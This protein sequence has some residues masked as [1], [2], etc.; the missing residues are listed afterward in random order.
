MTRL[1]NA[2][3]GIFA[4]LILH[5]PRRRPHKDPSGFGLSFAEQTVRTRDGHRLACWLV[6]P[7]SRRV[8]VLGHGIGQ[9]KSASLRTAQLLVARGYQVLM[10]DHRGHGA[11][12]GDRRIWRVADRFTD[13]IVSASRWMAERSHPRILVVFGYSFSTFP[14]VYALASGTLPAD[15]VVCESGPGLNLAGMFEGFLLK[16]SERSTPLGRLMRSPGLRHATAA[17]AVRMLGANWPPGTTEGLLSD[18]PQLY[19][20]GE[21]DTVIHPGEVS[22]LVGAWSCA[23]VHRIPGGHLRLSNSAGAEYDRLVGEFLYGVEQNIR[24]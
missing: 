23:E 20:V 12:Q 6:G 14:T 1:E 22:A 21:E 16:A 17:A 9:G 3:G 18:V 5:P 10:F 2:L 7:D 8:A 4:Y 24:G 19:L 15:A 11:S 13:D